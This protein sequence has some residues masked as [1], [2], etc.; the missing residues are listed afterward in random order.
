MHDEGEA[1]RAGFVIVNGGH[2]LF[3]TRAGGRRISRSVD[4]GDSRDVDPGAGSG[5]KD[6]ERK[7]PPAC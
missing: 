7:K 3:L 6:G 5:A 2:P 4:P 1:P